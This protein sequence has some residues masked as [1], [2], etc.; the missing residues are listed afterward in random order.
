MDWS[1]AK[2]ILIIAFIITN[3]ILIYA[4]YSNV[5]VDEPT[6]KEDFIQDAI[7]LL[8]NKN[9]KLNCEIPKEIPALSMITVEYEKREVAD[10]N[11]AFFNGFGYQDKKEE[12]G[13]KIKKDESEILT[14]LDGRNI[15]YE[16]NND[17]L[18]YSSLNKEKVIQIG[19]KFL[20]EKSYSLD[21]MKLTFYKEE[22]NTYFLEYTKVYEGIYVENTYTK[23]EIDHRGVKRFERLWMNVIDE[24]DGKIYISTAPKAVLSLLTMEETYGKTIEEIS[25]CYY[26]DPQKQVAVGNPQNTKQGKAIP[27][28]RIEFTDGYKVLLD[29]Y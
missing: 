28:W 2:T 20:K 10:L 18:K 6:I 5:T 16:N 29:E 3:L 17:E 11:K 4:L 14:I 8:S 12:R 9:I 1:K 25:L 26:F 7:N 23:L 24:S 13:V 15:I 22:G 27:A 21:D 19:Q